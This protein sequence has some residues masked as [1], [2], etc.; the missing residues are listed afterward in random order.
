MN[1]KQIIVVITLSILILF[2]Y[3][4][5]KPKENVTDH[6]Q[7]ENISENVMYLQWF[8]KIIDRN[9]KYFDTFVSNTNRAYIYDIISHVSPKL[10]KEFSLNEKFESLL[11]TNINDPLFLNSNDWSSNANV[12]QSVLDNLDLMKQKNIP[13]PDMHKE[14]DWEGLVN[15]YKLSNEENYGQDHMLYIYKRTLD[16]IGLVDYDIDLIEKEILDSDI[17]KDQ[18]VYGYFLTHIILYDSDSFKKELKYEDYESIIREIE[19]LTDFVI[20]TNNY[21]LAGELYI[22]L[23]QFQLKDNESLKKLDDFLFSEKAFN[24]I[25]K[26]INNHLLVVYLISLTYKME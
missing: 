24:R 21:D 9:E 22:C 6:I 26:S 2:L 11:S 20:A 3:S 17:K 25:S 1:K 12:F 13:I 15:S 16:K 14:Y 7:T 10:S 23:K 18:R 4:L 5:N 8:S 19:N